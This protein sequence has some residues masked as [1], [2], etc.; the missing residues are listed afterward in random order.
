MKAYAIIICLLFIHARSHAQTI[1]LVNT[2]Q[3][4]WRL[5]SRRIQRAFPNLA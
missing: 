3:A 5:A 2:R 4:N 1:N